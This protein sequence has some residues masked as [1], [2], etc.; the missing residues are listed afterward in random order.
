MEHL[1][2]GDIQ[3]APR[4]LAIDDTRDNLFILEKITA[5]YL[6]QCVFLSAASPT[7]GLE[8]AVTGGPDVILVDY[9]MPEMDGIEVCRRLK[10]DRNTA[11]IPVVILTAHE[12]S[13]K[14]R[15]EGLDAGADD[16]VSKPID[17]L[18][19]IARIKVMLRIKQ[20]EDSL[21]A[22]NRDLEEIVW[23]R[24][25]ALRESEERFRELFNH[26]S[27]G[28]AVFRAV[29]GGRDFIFTDLNRAG[30]R[31]DKIRREDV[32]GKSVK[33]LFPS[34]EEIG[35][36]DIF[37]RVWETGIPASLPVSYYRDERLEFWVENYVYKLPSGEIVAIHD[38]VTEKKRRNSR[39]AGA[40][41]NTVLCSSRAQMVS[42]SCHVQAGFSK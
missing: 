33:D 31:I 7:E 39:S 5:Q 37:R 17:N 18:E 12:S 29:D 38:D 19:F 2:C 15:S 13:P 35:L 1:H 27:S 6:P 40:R 42:L 9:Q 22:V 16:F 28:V 4:I 26:M 8:L 21:K 20:S 36:F 32:I 41:K 25:A 3:P 11:H 24:T 34:V 30:E 23:N 14:L 10:N